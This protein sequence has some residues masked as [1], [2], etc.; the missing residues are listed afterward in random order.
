MSHV[1]HYQLWWVW[2][3]Y[4]KVAEHNPSEQS[5]HNLVFDPL[6]LVAW[7]AEY[8]LGTIA[9]L[10]RH[11]FS[12]HLAH[13]ECLKGHCLF[14]SKYVDFTDHRDTEED[15]DNT[16]VVEAAG[17]KE[18]PKVAKGWMRV[19]WTT[20]ILLGHNPIKP[21]PSMQVRGFEP[22]QYSEVGMCL[23]FPSHMVHRTHTSSRGDEKLAF[24]WGKSGV[25]DPPR[26]G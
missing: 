8:E 17:E 3:T 7:Y 19:E 10:V 11:A 12:N 9:N 4:P 24:F 25:G 26:G 16:H 21:T 15:T 14:A 22:A 13:L 18:V 1:L 6:P 5:K 23:L 2:H 20:V